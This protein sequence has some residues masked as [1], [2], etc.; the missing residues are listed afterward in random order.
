MSSSHSR[1]LLEHISDCST[2]NQNN[3]MQIVQ[4]ATVECRLPS[5]NPA[6][7]TT[8]LQVQVWITGMAKPDSRRSAHPRRTMNR[9][10]R[11]PQLLIYAAEPG[12][13]THPTTLISDRSTLE[14]CGLKETEIK[15]HRAGPFRFLH[16]QPS[17]NPLLNPMRRS[18][19][20][21]R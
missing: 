19:N 8:I 6:L 12:S 17:G 4:P 11:R 5:I 2:G 9:V 10:P 15:Y 16:P 1:P 18:S 14:D 21:P 20:P 3:H 7:R 13:R